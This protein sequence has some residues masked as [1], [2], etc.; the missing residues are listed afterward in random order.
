MFSKNQ[1]D[2][3]SLRVEV[4]VWTIMAERAEGIS[5]TGRGRDWHHVVAQIVKTHTAT[6]QSK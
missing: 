2:R 3:D 6:K 5:H 4:V 1:K